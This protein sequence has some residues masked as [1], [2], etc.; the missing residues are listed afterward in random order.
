MSSRER[1]SDIESQGSSDAREPDREWV[2]T[3]LTR[4]KALLW[5]AKI[6]T[7]PVG[8]SGHYNP[9]GMLAAQRYVAEKYACKLLLEHGV[10]VVDVG[11]APHRTFEHLGDLGWYQMPPIVPGDRSRRGR[12]PPGAAE[13]VCTHRFEECMCHI[14]EKRSYLFTHSAYYLDPARLYETLVDELTVD[15]IAIEHRFDD[16][17]GGFYQ[18]ANWSV[19]RDGVVMTV[20][21]NSEP[22]RHPLPPWQAG[23]VGE[24]GRAIKG[25][26]LKVLDECTYV[27]RLHPVVLDGRSSE[28]LTWGEVVAEDSRSGPVQFSSAV[29]N[30]IADNA[31]FT[32]VTFNL[33]RVRKIGPFLYTDCVFRGDMIRLT[34]PVNGV[35]M[36]AAHVVNRERNPALFAEA[37]HFLKNRWAR[38]RI[39]PSLLPSVLAATV[40]LGFVVNLQNEVDLAYTMT[41]RFTWAMKVHGILLQFGTVIVR[42][43]VYLVVLFGLS[44]IGLVASEVLDDDTRFRVTAALLFLITW[45]LCLLCGRGVLLVHRRWRD[46][47][48]QGW[49]AAYGNDEG[50]RAPLLGQGFTLTKNLPLPG[51]RF[52]KPPPTVIQ[53]ELEVGASRENVLE[54]ARV[55]VSGIITD[56]A[57]PNAL[58]SGQEAELNA[59]L[60]RVLAPRD[61]PEDDALAEYTSVFAKGQAFQNVKSGIDTSK[62]AFDR[63]AAKL[64]ETYPADYVNNLTMLWMTNQGVEYPPVAT[65]PHLK[66]EKSAATVKSDTAKP[67]K[68]RLIQ[69]PEDIDK[70]VCGPVVWQLWDKIMKHW[71]G[72][73]SK[74]MYCSG[75][76]S[77][78]IG[79]RVDKFVS[80]HGDVVAWSV[81]MGMYDATLGLALQKPVIDWYV[82]LG[83]PS[84]MVHWL[85]RVRSRGVT[86]N[87]VKYMPVLYSWFF[88]EASAKACVKRLLKFKVKVLACKRAVNAENPD[89][90]WVVVH[91]D[92][93]MCSGRMDTNLTDTVALV[94]ALTARLPE[95]MPYL[96]LVCGDD[97]FLLMRKSD[98]GIVETLIDFA[99]RLGMKPEG[100][101]SEHRSNWE[102]C[103]KLFWY[104]VDPK[105]G[106]TKTVLGSKPF[107][108]IAR[109]GVN[110]TLPGAANAAAAALSVRIDSG[111]VPFLGAFADRTYEL[112]KAKKVKPTGKPEWTAIKGDRRFLPSP[113]NYVITQERYSLGEKNEDEFKAL[114]AVLD[115]VPIVLHYSPMEGAVAVDEA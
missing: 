95:E 89:L 110:T 26:I 20:A 38:T 40:A 49:V 93:Q 74:V 39:P 47:Q 97:G 41:Q 28:S 18:E 68:A 50:P 64:R 22:Y 46:Y 42:W 5:E 51:S 66:V 87:G 29:R 23:W 54:P 11:G 36:V 65:K 55:L 76:T 6:G 69:P 106:E 100:V 27:V 21:G 72:F 16:V 79:A 33:D 48:E 77:E 81:D 113:L 75:Y 90:E 70:A 17:F 61:G 9:H 59:V 99:R 111:H 63:W 85:L 19:D 56:G 105:T 3:T 73:R 10:R 101:V 2:G 60:N 52:L 4:A 102:F 7:K 88:D 13:H 94:G 1:E 80:E 92:L 57:V 12:C 14:G 62:T 104:G 84:W 78:Q 53:G 82:H 30:A 83:M 45:P 115:T 44:A 24:G 112:C 34:L 109:M 58:A 35:S 71:D 103:S 98:S 108:G 32:N 91:E 114:I 37:T 31:R 96:L 8:P 43:W 67:T 86:P 15:A 25:E 107:R